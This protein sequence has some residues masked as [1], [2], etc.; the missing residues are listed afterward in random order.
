M[1]SETVLQD[2]A[3]TIADVRFPKEYKQ[4]KH[5]ILG[6]VDVNLAISGVV[7]TVCGLQVKRQ[8]DAIM[9]IAPRYKDVN[10][11]EQHVML[12]PQELNDPIAELILS[13]FIE[14]TENDQT[15]H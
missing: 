12:I 10:G 11:I 5:G 6:V 3:I 2:I 15:I 4:K 8:G 14:V 1:N 9:I 7:I 13:I